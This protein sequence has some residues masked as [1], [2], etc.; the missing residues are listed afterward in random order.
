MVA[1]IH[2][3]RYI[4]NRTCEIGYFRHQHDISTPMATFLNPNRI[5][6]GATVAGKMLIIIE[7]GIL[8][9]PLSDLTKY[10]DVA[11]LGRTYGDAR[12]L[13]IFVSITP[14]TKS[15]QHQAHTNIDQV[16]TVFLG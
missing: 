9:A 12:P 2:F 11:I 6:F 14:R 7:P 13:D 3:A 1:L 8:V 15:F 10:W 4:A 5:E 16:E